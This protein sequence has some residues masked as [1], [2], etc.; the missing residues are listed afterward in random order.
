MGYYLFLI[1]FIS[2]A[3]LIS[4]KFIETDFALTN[5]P[6]FFIALTTMVIGMQLSLAG[7]IAELV[8]RNAPERNVYLI[9]KN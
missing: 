8:S 2:I 6:A 7:F 9:Q 3:Y 5:R 4:A 1:G